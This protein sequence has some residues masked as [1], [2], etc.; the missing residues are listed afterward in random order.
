VKR[1]RLNISVFVLILTL[2]SFPSQGVVSGVAGPISGSEP[3]NSTMFD[4]FSEAELDEL[5]APIALYPDPLLA[6]LLPASTFVDQI[7]EAQKTLNGKSDDNLIANQSWDISV[8]SIAH[9][10]TVLQAMSQKSDWTTALGQA[11][12]GQAADVEKAIQRLRA[13]AKDAGTLVSNDKVLV[14]TKTQSGQQVIAVEP[15]QPEVIY[16]PQYDPQ[17]VY[18]Q[19]GPS[20]GSVV[21]AS[22][23]SF[24]V[25]MAMGAWLNRG[26]NWYGGGV[27]YHGWS[28]GGWIGRSANVANINVNRNVYVN[29]SYRNINV[30][31]NVT[32]RNI[33]SYRTNL[34]RD[35][36]TAGLTRALVMSSQAPATMQRAL[37]IQGRSI[38][39]A[40]AT[41][42]P[43]PV[44]A[45]QQAAPVKAVRQT[46]TVKATLQRGSKLL[47][48]KPKPQRVR[49]EAKR[50]PRAEVVGSKRL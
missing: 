40:A 48:Q 12:V 46:A 41:Q 39:L 37:R 29:N 23:L 18:V 5:L 9:Y 31:R 8:K 1:I 35:A 11:Y 32:N 4:A 47:N 13:Q 15:A 25:G 7:A 3:V 33:S 43:P 49:Q 36:T 19:Q 44:K 50:P 38:T 34:Q 17:V 22:M 42:K 27:Y 45:A 20:T 28:G 10:P 2:V 16:V 21:A 30:D 26:W 24:G 6:Q 14:E